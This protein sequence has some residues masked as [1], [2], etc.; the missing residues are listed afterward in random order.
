MYDNGSFKS[1]WFTQVHN[2]LNELG[3]S[4]M[5]IENEFDAKQ[6]K[7]IVQQKTT[8]ASQQNWQSSVNESGVCHK[9]KLSKKDL[10][11]ES[12]TY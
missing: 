10:K 6:F 2:N 7:Y 4:Y 8:D 5:W 9:C 3:L 11:R 1:K 12:Y